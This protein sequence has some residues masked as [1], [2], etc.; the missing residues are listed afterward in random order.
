MK[1]T[2]SGESASRDADGTK[3]RD[4]RYLL[5]S[6]ANSDDAVSLRKTSNRFHRSFESSSARRI[7]RATSARSLAHRSNYSQT[8]VSD[9]SSH[10]SCGGVK[11]T[12]PG[13]HPGCQSAVIV[14]CLLKTRT[15]DVW[16]TREVRRGDSSPGLG[17]DALDLLAI[18]RVITKYKYGSYGISSTRLV[19]RLRI[20]GTECLSSAFVQIRGL[21]R[22][23]PRSLLRLS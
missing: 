16:A 4:A 19:F 9:H 23:I 15:V 3:T 10:R 17:A 1:L 6:R 18:D 13:D 7:F 21:L 5:A 11:G 20:N 14:D 2:T 12:P 22:C 8:V